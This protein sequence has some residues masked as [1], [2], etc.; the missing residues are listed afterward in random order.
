MRAVFA[1]PCSMSGTKTEP[2]TE[3]RAPADTLPGMPNPDA[4]PMRTA[5]EIHAA[6][7]ALALELAGRADD[8][9]KPSRRFEF[10]SPA[11]GRDLRGLPAIGRGVAGA[12]A[13]TQPGGSQRRH[14]DDHHDGRTPGD[15]RRMRAARRRLGKHRDTAPDA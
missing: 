6:N 3:P 4:R 15:K 10:Q 9:P 5:A 12:I 13:G 11:D 14:I 2:Q 1:P 8:T 7:A